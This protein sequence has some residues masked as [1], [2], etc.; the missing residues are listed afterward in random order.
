VIRL[1]PFLVALA[2]ACGSPAAVGP[3]ETS[4]TTAVSS[5]SAAPTPSPQPK[6]TH[7]PGT[8]V[9]ITVNG[10]DLPEGA[11]AQLDGD[12]SALVVIAFP[13]AM[14]RA[15]VE[16]FLPRSATASWSDDQT[17][18]VAIPATESFP[19]FK[20]PE[21]LSKDDSAIVDIFFVNLNPAPSLVVSMFSVDE[22][23][24]GARA[25]RDTA[26]R[27]R[28]GAQVLRFSPD[29]RKVLMYQASDL[30]FGDRATRIF[31]LES[32]STM[33]LPAMLNGPLLEGAW[34]GNDR[35][36][37]VGDAVWIASADGTGAR[38]VKDLSSLSTPRTASVSP[39]G[40]Y[41]ALEWADQLAI[42]DLRSGAMRAIAD[43]RDDCDLPISPLSRVAWSQDELRLAMLECDASTA[44]PRVRIAEIAS[45]RIV[46]TI[47]GGEL[48]VAP[49]LS[50]DFALA[51]ESGERGEGSRRLFVVYSFDGT[52]KGRYLGYAISASPNGRYLLDGSCCAG[53]G[54]ALTD[55]S[56]PGQPKVGF[57]GSATWLRDGRVLVV[58]HPGGSR[59]RVVP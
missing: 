12:A 5:P 51:R 40:S 20:V 48:G 44:T 30:P 31:D 10:A 21:S 3:A 56:A 11:I 57:A 33:L 26:A 18:T 41:V 49:L 47:E 14:D 16:R 7:L 35:I 54:S 43:H 17:L 42:V 59:S 55:L 8:S 23:L 36:V 39:L 37:L 46:K 27:I 45:G 1:A 32:R 22:L 29:A 13:V 34:A 28:S 50:G 19:A 38:N 24:A 6:P 58:M 15:S 53:E 52:E 25:P 2:V 9:R 4:P